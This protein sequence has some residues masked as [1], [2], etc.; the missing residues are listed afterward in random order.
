VP[1]SIQRG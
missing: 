1:R